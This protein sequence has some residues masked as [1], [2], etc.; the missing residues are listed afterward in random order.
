M[1]DTLLFWAKL[2]S[3]VW[4]TKY[5]PAI[6][7][8]ID[9]GQVARRLWDDVCRQRVKEWVRAAA[10]AA[11]RNTTGAWLAFWVAAHD[12]GKICPGFQVLGDDHRTTKLRAC[13]PA[14]PW[15]Y[16]M[17]TTLH[18]TVSTA[19]A[20]TAM[21]DGLG[22]PAVDGKTA[23]AHRG[24]HRR[25]PRHFPDELGQLLIHVGNAHWQMAQQKILKELARLFGVADL[26]APNP[27]I[28]DDQS[29]WMYLAGLTSV[30][31]WV[32]SNVEF[33]PPFGNPSLVDGQADVNAYFAD[34][35]NKASVALGKLGWLNRVDKTTPIAFGEL[36]PFIPRPLQTAV[37]ELVEGMTEPGLLIVEA[38]MGEGKTEAGW[39]A[40]ASWDRHGGQGSYSRAADDGDK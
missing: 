31:D 30:A 18:A 5:H 13:L 39:F 21:Q 4:P 27:P 10:R 36:F 32:G 19:I 15:D 20:V 7:H 33:F 9:V 26:P 38:P 12:I 16:P 24:R 23:P 34:A 40:A 14:P 25:P 22:W 3:E 1:N 29:V 2:G 6:C 17:G 35:A 11:R 37:A 8:L 28:A